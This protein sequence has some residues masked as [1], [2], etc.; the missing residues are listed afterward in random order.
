MARIFRGLDLG[1][2]AGIFQLFKAWED[3]AGPEAAAHSCPDHISDKCLYV[4]VDNPVWTT[5]LG[6]RKADLM[7]GLAKTGT[8]KDIK[9]IK[10][11]IKKFRFLKKTD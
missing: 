4:A 5:E 2:S 3:I 1:E 10:F 8:D 9:D 11:V 7:T 6:F